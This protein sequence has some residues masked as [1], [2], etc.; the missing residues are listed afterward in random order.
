[1]LAVYS[2]GECKYFL[3]SNLPFL[4]AMSFTFHICYVNFMNKQNHII[5]PNLK[6]KIIRNTI[7]ILTLISVITV[8]IVI[9]HVILTP[10][11]EQYMVIDLFTT[12]AIHRREV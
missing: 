11:R 9:I 12:T 8:I 3:L 1:M 6:G 7:L 2:K 4:L 10:K 5:L